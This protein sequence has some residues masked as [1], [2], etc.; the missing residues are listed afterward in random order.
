MRYKI[1]D[2]NEMNELERYEAMRL[3]NLRLRRVRWFWDYG[4]IYIVVL[5]GILSIVIVELL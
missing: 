1:E 3:E 5:L 4:I 2:F